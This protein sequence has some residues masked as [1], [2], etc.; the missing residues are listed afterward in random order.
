VGIFDGGNGTTNHIVMQTSTYEF[1][2]MGKLLLNYGL[3]PLTLKKLAD[4]KIE[5]FLRI[6]KFLDEGN[7]LED[8]N[9][10]LRVVGFEGGDRI[11]ISTYLKEQGIGDEFIEEFV[12]GVVSGIYNQDYSNMHTVGGM[13]SL[14]ATFKKTYS[15]TG[16]NRLMLKRL[17]E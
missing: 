10:F 1:I 7:V 9:H 16:G 3:S 14:I 2:T 6:Y 4:R 15:V 5:D 12:A 8:Y 13:I 17:V 11:A